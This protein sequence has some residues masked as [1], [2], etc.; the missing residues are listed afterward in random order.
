LKSRS[1]D[2]GRQFWPHPATD[3]TQKQKSLD[4]FTRSNPYQKSAL[5]SPL[6]RGKTP[7]PFRWGET[8]T[9]FI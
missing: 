6:A 3:K 2:P 1:A 9:F 8:R 7:Y 4:N 5:S